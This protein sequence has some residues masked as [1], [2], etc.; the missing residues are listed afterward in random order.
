MADG[1]FSVA[2]AIPG[3]YLLT[4]SDLPDD[5]YVRA[6]RQGPEDVLESTVAV[7]TES[8]GPLQILLG[9]DGGR[10]N[11]SVLRRD[12]GTAAGAQVVLVPDS[13]RRNRPDQ[14]RVG[15]S[16]E[17]GLVALHGIPP[18]DYKLFAWEA[19]DPNAY[20]NED[21]MRTYD[22]LGLP[23]RVRSGENGSIQLRV[24][25]QEP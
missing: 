12:G 9:S 8:T 18:G 10:L 6:V 7:G 1:G 11:A 23:I 2:D 3:E 25:S 19:I 4:V 15:T 17:D 20:R 21:Y 24:I 16:G 22:R 5:V 13:A 14:Y